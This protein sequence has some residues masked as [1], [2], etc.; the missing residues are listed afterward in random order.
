M[1]SSK[2][3]RNLFSVESDVNAYRNGKGYSSSPIACLC[4]QCNT[5]TMHMGNHTL[6]Q[7]THDQVLLK[8]TLREQGEYMSAGYIRNKWSRL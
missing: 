1:V 4:P 7:E 2:A 8:P 6:I 3:Q 5:T